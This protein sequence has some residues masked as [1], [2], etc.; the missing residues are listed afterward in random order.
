MTGRGLKLGP[1]HKKSK[2]QKLQEELER[3]M[4]ANTYIRDEPNQRAW[5][6]R[7]RRRIRHL[8]KQLREMEV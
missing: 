3:L 6:E 1:R 4:R 2:S 5:Y 7:N 8:R